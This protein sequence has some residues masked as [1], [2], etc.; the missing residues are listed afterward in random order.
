M[1]STFLLFGEMEYLNDVDLRCAL[2]RMIAL[3]LAFLLFCYVLYKM[4][5]SATKSFA[6][7]L[8]RVCFCHSTTQKL[9]KGTS[10][11]LRLRLLQHYSPWRGLSFV[12]RLSLSFT[13]LETLWKREIWLSNL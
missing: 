10:F 9:S 4:R 3:S 8:I 11:W 2:Y 5:T 7:F 13:M 1:Q 12:C 6:K